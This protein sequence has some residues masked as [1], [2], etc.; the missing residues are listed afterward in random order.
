MFP[1]LNIPD[2]VFLDLPNPYVK[3]C[4]PRHICS[5]CLSAV[6]QKVRHLLIF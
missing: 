6:R 2:T 1:F 5:T 3:T 4:N